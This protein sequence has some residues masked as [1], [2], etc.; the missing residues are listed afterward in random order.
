MAQARREHLFPVSCGALYGVITDYESYPSFVEGIHACRILE[1]GEEGGR[2]EMGLHM[3]KR[4]TY[5]LLV[6]HERPHRV[7][8]ELES[9]DI[10]KANSGSWS[11]REE[12]E[13]QCRATYEVTVEVKGFFPGAKMV[14]KTLTD[15]RLPAMMASYEKEALR[16]THG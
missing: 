16:R 3:I 12:G 11:L 6:A 15:I 1:M 14:A 9:G 7:S 8:W 4:L 5:T 2:V 10:F 13:G